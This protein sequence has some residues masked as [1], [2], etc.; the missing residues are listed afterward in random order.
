LLL[1]SIYKASINS[2]P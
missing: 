1:H 2:Y